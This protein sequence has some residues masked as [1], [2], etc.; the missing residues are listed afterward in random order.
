MD[1]GAIAEEARPRVR[2]NLQLEARSFERALLDRG[3]PYEQGLKAAWVE[4]PS[5]YPRFLFEEAYRFFYDNLL[6]QEGWLGFSLKAASELGIPDWDYKPMNFTLHMPRP[7]T[8]DPNDIAF[9][10]M[11]VDRLTRF[12]ATTQRVEFT[13][14]AFVSNNGHLRELLSMLFTSGHFNELLDQVNLARFPLDGEGALGE[15]RAAIGNR[16][17]AFQLFEKRPP[18]NFIWEIS[19]IS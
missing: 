12:D 19:S 18:P 6:P 9:V 15:L 8:Y 13:G 16:E 4:W 10:S 14:G 17:W 1:F 7:G 5:P 11:L 3:F 2:S